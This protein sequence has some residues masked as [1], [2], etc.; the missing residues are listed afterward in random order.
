M[1]LDSFDL[2]FITANKELSHYQY[3]AELS[4]VI[5]TP[6]S[7][8]GVV[9]KGLSANYDQ[10]R[11]SKFLRKGS[12]PDYSLENL[13]EEVLLT[14]KMADRLELD[15]DSSFVM[16]FVREGKEPLYRRM[17]IKGI[18]ST[19]IQ[20]IDENY[21]IMDL[22]QI[23]RINQ[24]PR[25][26][27]GG[28]EMFVPDIEHVDEAYESLRPQE[29]FQLQFTKASDRF[30]AIS[31]WINWFDNNI[32]I[33][34][35]LMMVVVTIN[36]MMVL[37]ILIIE[38]TPSIG[39]LK[40]LGASNI[41]IRSVFIQYAL[42]IMVP[43]ILIGNL[44]ALAFLLFQKTTQFIKLNPDNYY[45]NAVPVYLSPW[46]ILAISV[47]ALVIAAIILIIPS[48]VISKISPIKA[49]KFD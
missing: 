1:A 40:T 39:I 26:T 35:V 3:F 48:M 17:H 8:D 2:Q 11:F 13:S 22:K 20:D 31:E 47:G 43:G 34:I 14:Q 12:L 27:V 23:Q 41:Q 36:M 10:E 32:F 38:R 5:R 37:V 45:V 49:I 30:S 46:F 16:Y 21:M 25:N 9:A 24:W 6:T 4:G 7:F 33:I 18:F 15:I 44:V 29:H 28:I 42:M 19:E